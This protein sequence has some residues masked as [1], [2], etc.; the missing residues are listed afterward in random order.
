[1][2]FSL[3]L[4]EHNGTCALRSVGRRVRV[5]REQGAKELSG[6]DHRDL[7]RSITSSRR[8]RLTGRRAQATVSARTSPHTAAVISKDSDHERVLRVRVRGRNLF[9]GGLGVP[10]TSGAAEKV[11]GG[12][13]RSG[14]CGTPGGG[15]CR[16]RN[17]RRSRRC[18]IG[19]QNHCSE[20]PG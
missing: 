11:P 4:K 15:R 13:R 8:E 10:E 17:R 2:Q 19:M 20:P 6:G 7:A 12:G 9:S 1:M 16:A 18:S 3:F 14:W 5:K